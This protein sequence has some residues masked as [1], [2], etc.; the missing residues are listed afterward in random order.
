MFALVDKRIPVAAKEKLAAYFQIVEFFS[1]G[2]VYEAICGH[3]DIFFIR[4]GKTL[5]VAPNVPQ[6]YINML[7]ENKVAY[8][9]GEKPL[10][11]RYPETAS[12]NVSLNEFTLV[13]KLT[14]TDKIVLNQSEALQKI[15][16]E[17]GYTRCNL[18]PLKNNHWITS[19]K[20]IE[21]KLKILNYS[22]LR[23]DSQDVVLPG[24]QH[25][26]FGGACGVLGSRIFII[27]SLKYFSKR[28]CLR[29]FLEKIDYEIV[30]LYDGPLFDGG[31]ILFFE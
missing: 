22:V 27:G 8:F 18:L 12:Y 23:V 30:E 19:D 14:I 6:K 7:E 10:G 17:Q 3:P 1:E 26:F 13:H 2:I 28:D 29:T 31:S 16:V 21:K 5:I 20:G 25:G 24:A 11:K 15:D 9:L 4:I